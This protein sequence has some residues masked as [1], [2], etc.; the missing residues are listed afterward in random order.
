METNTS[1]I[2]VGRFCYS[3]EKLVVD[4][5]RVLK[6]K[7]CPYWSKRPYQPSQMD[8]FCAYLMQGD[9]QGKGK[10]NLLWDQVKSC[11]INL[12]EK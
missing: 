1:L 7:P 11:D 3:R 2:P 6:R 9:W 4:G 10:F 5:K 8:G 12:K